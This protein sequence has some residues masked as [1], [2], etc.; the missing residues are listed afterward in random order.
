M[1]KYTPSPWEWQWKPGRLGGMDI[2]I[3]KDNRIIAEILNPSQ[4]A[5]LYDAH[6]IAAAPEMFEV[7]ETI[8]NDAG[9]V[10]DWLWEEIQAV[11]AKARGEE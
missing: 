8:E 6:L 7:L 11:V 2:M 10:P 3:Y 1:R 5:E 9:Q 4:G